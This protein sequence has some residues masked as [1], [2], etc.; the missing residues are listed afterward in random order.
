MIGF[1]LSILLIVTIT[2]HSPHYYFYGRMNAELRDSELFEDMR[3]GDS[4]CFIGDSITNGSLTGGV[5][6]HHHLDKYIR[7]D[8]LDFSGGGWTT[9]TLVKNKELIPSAD[10][11]VF[12]IGIND[13]MYS[14]VD[15]GA[16]TSDEFIDN[17]R[18]VT[19]RIREISPDAK[20]YF[21]APWVFRNFPDEAFARGN[22][23]SDSLKIWCDTNGFICVDPDP[24]IL[25]AIEEDGW[26]RYMVD[27][28]HPNAERGVGLYSYA[29][30][31][32]EHRR[33]A[34]T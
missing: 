13:V 29:V 23:Y 28:V 25:S 19:E 7:G 6:W 27:N 33:T 30:L 17:L 26:E 9:R 15:L 18:I 1:L 31:E 21:I 16:T 14:D 8:I 12:A 24:I 3:S 10:I 34:E 32:A 4:F 20:F 2:L 22:D 5:S 11:Y